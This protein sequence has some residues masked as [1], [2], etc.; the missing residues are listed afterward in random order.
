MPANVFEFFSSESPLNPKFFAY[1]SFPIYLLRILGAFA[2]TPALVVPWREDFVGLALLG[3]ALSALFDLGTIALTFLLARRLY[4]ATTG[5]IASACI[6]VTV[7]HIQLS[8]FYAVDTLLTLLVV[9]TM[10]FAARFAQAGKR[11][12]AIALGIAFGLALATKVSAAP[13]VVPIV[14]AVVQASRR[15]E[16]QRSRGEM[17]PRSPAPL[18]PYKESFAQ[19]WRARAT[20]AR[21]LAVALAAFIVTQPY[22]LLDPIRYFGQIGTESL[23][24]RGW[25]DY[26]YTRQYA[27]T[28]PFVYPIVQSSVWGMGLPLGIFA[29]LGSA[30]FAYR[31]WRARDWR[32]GL[33]LSWALVYFLIVGGQY[34]KYLRY[35]LP[36]LPFL[37][38]MAASSFKVQSSRFKVLRFTHHALLS[39][40]Y[41]LLL[42]VSLGYALAFTSLYSR[43]H[44][45]LTIS[46]W[47]YANVPPNATIAVEH[48]D[49]VLPV[50]IQMADATRAPSEYKTLMLPM[51]DDDNATKLEMIVNT[52][53]ESDY[54]VL[55]TQRLSAP[56]TR[57]PQRYPISS[58]Y[59]HL[60][61]SGQLG[62]EFA[63]S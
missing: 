46:K 36:L 10:F 59:Y 53:N 15:A 8:H 31:F 45:W 1:G 37:F 19:I 17:P 50:P 60:L 29:W 35:L 4:D 40:V 18:L 52:L 13:L 41:G 55:A 6:A 34:A 48:W 27:D 33:I 26:P 16:E 23:V 7:L 3:R 12:D 9:A 49:D 22:A 28:L 20:L 24:A 5:L 43:E 58:R 38:L 42:T 47:I 56:I 51:Y 62:F 30:L 21:I 11:L 54:I 25:L 32:D 63:A 61:F 57:L 39:T 14:V 2:P 44:P